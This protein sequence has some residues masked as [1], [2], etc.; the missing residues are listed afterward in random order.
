MGQEILYCFKC[1]ERV[2]SA[3]LEAAKGLR[4][5]LRTACK[6]CVPDL[7]ATLTEQERK[8]LV[9]KVQAASTPDPRT[10]TGKYVLSTTTPRSRSV[11]AVPARPASGSNSVWAVAVG[12]VLIV[13]AAIAFLMN[14]GGS[15]PP[16]EA[17][18]PPPTGK[19]ATESSRDRAA[20]EALN[21]AKSLSASDLEAQVSAYAEAA[22]L[23]GATPYEREARERYEGM[24]D[25][26]RKAYVREIVVIEERAK[27]LASK[28]E[29]GSSIALFEAARTLHAAPEWKT[30]IDAEVE[31]Y[32]KA[33][34]TAFADVKAKASLARE[35]GAED[36]LKVLLER[37]SRW[38]LPQ[39][40]KDLEAH[41]AALPSPVDARPWTPIFDGKS[42]D[43][44]VSN[45]E[46]A[47]VV[48][49]G[50]LVHV[51]DRKQSAQTKRQFTDGEFRI[52][53]EERQLTHAGFALRQ[54]LGYYGV[55][56]NRVELGQMAGR[57]HELLAVFRGNEVLVTL[58]GKP[59]K[60]EKFGITPFVGPLQFN[61]YGEYFAVKSLEFREPAPADGLV[62]HWTFDSINGT[63][64][65]DSSP[66][67]NDGLL[68]DAPVPVA[69]RL[70]NALQFDGRRSYVKVPSHPALILT[71]PFTLS[72]WVKPAIGSWAPIRSE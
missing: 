70:G 52:R 72:A 2:T 19:P 1:Q 59:Q 66:S 40:G 47:W 26:R 29:F 54:G 28:E 63:T 4:F 5:G 42:L 64:A 9:A 32:R 20:R 44:L 27:A 58:D 60:V 37:V 11:P 34:E 65:P 30:Q 25:M 56:W 23:A 10:S 24:L 21:R 48:E 31:L 69:G 17:P 68:V 49:N 45:G 36:E 67:K 50:G 62:G 43:F 6:K 35:K 12:V 53:F 13:I 71:G 14:L 46:G 55:A 3:E 16:R 61:V 18:T 15:A 51:K 41:L 39:L 8:D 57:E 38:S 33:A 22:R 7:L